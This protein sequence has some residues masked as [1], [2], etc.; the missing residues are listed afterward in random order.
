M[1]NKK[2]KV[3][4]YFNQDFILEDILSNKNQYGE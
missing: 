2:E 1:V 3:E 4:T